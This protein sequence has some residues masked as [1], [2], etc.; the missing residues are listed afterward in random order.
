M[1]SEIELEGLTWLNE[2]SLAL[3]KNRAAAVF[4]NA[5]IFCEVNKIE[6]FA[7]DHLP[8]ISAPFVLLTGQKMLPALSDGESARKILQNPNLIRWFSQ[9]QIFEH[10]DIRPFPY[11]VPFDKSPIIANQL[12][13]S[14]G[15]A[16]SQRK[17]T[18]VPFARVHP[19]LSE[20]Q[21][22]I[23]QEAASEQCPEL[24][25]KEY[26]REISQSLWVVSPPGDRPDTYRHW[27]SIALGAVPISVRGQ[28]MERLFGDSMV[29]HKKLVASEYKKTSP[30][31]F[32]PN[33]SLATVRKW[34]AEIDG[35]I[36]FFG[37]GEAGCN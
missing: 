29:F 33:P 2:R 30:L 23:R 7:S 28:G 5:V 19:H 12:K 9:N 16:N 26:I 24:P 3:Q 34:Q 18:F 4:P 21:A 10:L 6:V 22:R 36:K 20:E 25:Y 17:G 35:E 14:M 32:L 1:S 8:L 27:E 37:D 11:G 13:K 15:S 31:Q